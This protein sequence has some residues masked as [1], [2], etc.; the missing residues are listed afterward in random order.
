MK[1]LKFLA[2]AVG[3]LIACGASAQTKI[4]YI[5]I[6]DIVSLMP[7]LAPDKVNLDTVG[8]K[9]VADSVAPRLQYVQAEY[10]RKTQEYSDT[11]KPKGVRE[12][13]FKDLLSLKEELD[14]ADNLVQQA[15]QFKQNEFL[16]PFYAKAKKAIDAAA[17][18][19][20]YTYVMN[21]DVFLVA[22]ETDD[23]SL[24][25]LAELGIKPPA[26]GTKPQPGKPGGN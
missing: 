13:I 5:R 23:L 18:K 19:K 25:V 2:V 4:G 1:K 21:T 6:D 7:E 20:G 15:Y 24:A 11:T 3:L 26:A 12:Q 17:K 16:R 22:P 8:Q 10:Q 14:G 9:F